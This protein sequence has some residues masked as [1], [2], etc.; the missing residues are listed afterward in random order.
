MKYTLYNPLYNP[1]YNLVRSQR[2]HTI[3][4]MELKREFDAAHIYKM[5]T[6]L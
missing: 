2:E 1:M 3:S 5:K 6:N 4:F